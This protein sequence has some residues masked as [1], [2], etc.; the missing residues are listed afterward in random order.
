MAEIGE[1]MKR[2][3]LV[4]LCILLSISVFAGGNSESGPRTLRLAH[5]SNEAHPSH[6]G[7]LKFKEIVE[8]ETNGELKVEIYSNAS[9]G[10]AEEY[11]EQIK[12]GALDMGLV[13]SGQLQVWI[14]EYAAVMIPFLF[15]SYDHAHRALDGE[16]GVL[17]C[18]VVSCGISCG[19][20]FLLL[21][22]GPAVL[23]I[24]SWLPPAIRR[25]LR[26]G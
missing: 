19:C 9:L 14:P 21:R 17:P 24:P 13:T 18:G 10:A 25:I 1:I 12:L 26:S 22:P 16:A 2:I 20:F 15:E 5:I 7:A 4:T 23:L 8:S 3:I 11:T 6:L